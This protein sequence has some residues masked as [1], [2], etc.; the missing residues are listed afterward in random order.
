[1]AEVK[2]TTVEATCPYCEQSIEVDVEVWML[3]HTEDDDGVNVLLDGRVSAM[4][5]CEH[6]DEYDPEDF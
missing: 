6:A 5:G 4:R 1:V 3:G 2:S